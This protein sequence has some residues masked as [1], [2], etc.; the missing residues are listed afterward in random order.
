[1]ADQPKPLPF[2]YQFA[3]G[4]VAGVSEIL[5]MYTLDVVK[6]RV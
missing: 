1:M 3:D 2:V 4:A 6:T 5:V